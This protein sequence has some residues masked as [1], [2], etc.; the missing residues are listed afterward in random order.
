M[1]YITEKVVIQT[2]LT[3]D[4]VLLVRP[5]EDDDTFQVQT[6]DGNRRMDGMDDS[7]TDG[8]TS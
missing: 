5:S 1:N 8:R 2:T 4:A 3:C 6:L 7:N